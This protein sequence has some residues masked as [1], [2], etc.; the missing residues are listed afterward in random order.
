MTI[1]KA[2]T[3]WLTSSALSRV[4]KPT[5]RQRLIAH[6][7]FWIGTG[8]FQIYMHTWIL[9]GVSWDVY[10]VVLS[11]DIPTIAG[12]YYLFAYF[13]LPSIYKSRWL[14]VFVCLAGIY[15]LN[16]LSNYLLYG[17][18]ANTYN[19]LTTIPQALGHN[20]FLHVLFGANTLLIN[21][22][23]TL[24]SL[25]VPIAGKIVKDMLM[26]RTRSAEL[27]RDNLK[28]ELN[29]LQNQIQPHFV[30][31]SLNSVYSMVAGT[32]DEAGSILLRLSK[33]LQ[34]ALYETANP[35][36]PLVREIDF[37]HEYIGLEAIRQHERTTLSFQHDGPLEKFQIPPLLLVTFVENAFKHGI[38]STYRQAWADIR[39]QTTED[40][41]LH[42]RV[43]NS[44]PPVDVRQKV[45]NRTAGFGIAN[46][47]RRLKLLFPNR[48]TLTI[49]DEDDTFTVELVL[50]LMPETIA[51][52]ILS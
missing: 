48:H 22:S 27:E 1:D 25:A 42:F 5:F 20:G 31:N 45:V 41:Y 38:N 15:T 17:W 12:S 2:P 4:L 24:S 6:S 10:L 9:R 43:E 18:I 46:T 51:I 52:P 7:I 13:G 21:W 26:I 14:N 35:I 23:F 34:Y 44:K 16:T 32:D 40:G 33:L 50:Q 29:F 19:I 30:L 11:F 36:I 49:H 8:L 28:L 47:Q 3:N 37:L 39:V